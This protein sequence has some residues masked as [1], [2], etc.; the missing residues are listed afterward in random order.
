MGTTGNGD[1]QLNAPY[2]IAL[3]LNGSTVSKVWVADYNNHRVQAFDSNGTFLSKIGTHG[4]GNSQL[5]HASGVDITDN[6][7][8][9]SSRY[10]NKI[11]VFETNGTYVRSI[12]SSGRTY[13]LDSSGNK[14]AVCRTDNHMVEIFDKNGSLLTT[15][16][17]N[18][19]SSPGLF[20]T[21]Y[22]LAFDPHGDLHVSCQI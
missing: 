2:A 13:D 19:S 5:Y 20:N 21:P 3:D 11:K 9:V 8:Y 6:L 7:I 16:G 14:I 1:G 15:I 10:H 22:G 17:T 18:A 12:N 4:N